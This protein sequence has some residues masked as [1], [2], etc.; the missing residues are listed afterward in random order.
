MINSDQLK[1]NT[2]SIFEKATKEASNVNI[3]GDTATSYRFRMFDGHA[4]DSSI[5]SS[6]CRDYT[7][8]VPQGLINRLQVLAYLTLYA[9]IEKPTHFPLAATDRRD[10][11]NYLPY[12][13]RPI[14]DRKS[15]I[16]TRVVSHLID[17][18]CDDVDAD[19]AFKM[20][21]ASVW[22]MTLF[23]LYHELGHAVEGHVE[24]KRLMQRDPNLELWEMTLCHSKEDIFEGFEVRADCYAAQHM[25]AIYFKALINSLMNDGQSGALPSE[26]KFE[27]SGMRFSEVASNVFSHACAEIAQMV[28]LFDSRNRS[29]DRKGMGY[30]PH[31]LIRYSIITKTLAKHLQKLCESEF[32]PAPNIELIFLDCSK[33][34]AGAMSNLINT[35]W[36]REYL[37]DVREGL[38]TPKRP[39]P[40]CGI[41]FDEA[42]FNVSVREEYTFRS[43]QQG[44]RIP[45]IFEATEFA[46]AGFSNPAMTPI[47]Y[48]NA[49][50]MWDE[51]LRTIKEEAYA[52]RSTV[53]FGGEQKKKR[54]I[55]N[56]F[57]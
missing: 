34:V 52:G 50:V 49:A 35:I 43:Y 45:L 33:T 17:T 3:P 4:P 53:V 56:I 26:W 38:R 31:P 46:R 30:Y 51:K 19:H 1:E 2:L 48:G 15:T 5:V 41:H 13:L 40:L 28:V 11:E 39:L 29:L 37:N 57:K 55:W 9:K 6:R 42:P 25:A 22:R 16:D 14:F 32:R 18:W 12:Q 23:V 20:I 24:F 27:M 54:S 8:F 36:H 44:Q 10:L 7:I 47:K 21:S